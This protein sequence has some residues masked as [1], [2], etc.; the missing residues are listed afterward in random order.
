MTRELA[1]ALMLA[2]LALLLFLI[3]RG[4]NRRTRRYSAL[5]DLPVAASTMPMPERFFGLLYVATTEADAPLE[6]IARRPLAFRAKA[7]LGVG[8]QGVWLEIPGERAV[9]LES[10]TLLGVGR[11]TWTI[12]RVVDR[13]GL[14]VLRWQWGPQTVDS[15]FR[16][17][18]YPADDI[19]SVIDETIT[20]R[21]EDQ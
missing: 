16:S 1:A 21:Q 17:V 6:R 19:V 12:D 10:S 8:P 11:A 7:R 9:A 18:D 4:W 13:D 3:W 2:L 14:I 15:Y 20:A 5:P